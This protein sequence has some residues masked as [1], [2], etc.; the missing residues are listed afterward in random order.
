MDEINVVL[1]VTK[2]PY[3]IRNN[4]RATALKIINKKFFD[5][6]GSTEEL[7]LRVKSDDDKRFF[8][9]SINESF[10]SMVDA[11]SQAN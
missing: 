5:Y 9:Y 1:G 3:K 11:E 2:K 4:M 7:I 8:T 6:R 10:I